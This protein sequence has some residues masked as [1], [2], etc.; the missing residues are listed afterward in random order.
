MSEFYKAKRG[1]DWNFG[2]SKWKLSR[3]KIDLFMGCPR[4]FY[5]DNRLGVARPRGPA[6][7]LNIAVDKLLK[8]EFDI[9][10]AGGSAHPIMKKYG[11]KAVPFN[12]PDVEKWRDNFS[13]VQFF[14]APTG[15]KIS[16]AIDDVW[17]FPDGEL[18]VVDYKA[19]AK[20]GDVTELSDTKWQNQYKRQMEIYQWLLRRNGFKVSMTGYFLYVNGKTDRKAFDGKLEF[21]VNLIAHKGDDSWIPDILDKIKKCLAGSEIP[22]A[23]PEC[24]FC[25]Y[26]ESAGRSF[27]ES[28]IYAKENRNADHKTRLIKIDEKRS[29]DK[30]SE[31]TASLF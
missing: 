24:E 19:T 21:D 1:A 30:K 27:R 7:T 23:A 16:G 9:H 20:D 4:C 3:S 25:A 29:A 11:V 2:G 5:L 6:F 13:G 28:L 15:M 26:R 8:K 10:R 17:V 31:S 12:H 22:K 14:H 18:I